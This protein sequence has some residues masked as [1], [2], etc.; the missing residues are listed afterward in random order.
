[1]KKFGKTSLVCGGDE[2]TKFMPLKKIKSLD[3][4]SVSFE[5]G[6]LKK[7]KK[8]FVKEMWDLY[9]NLNKQ[10][11]TVKEIDEYLVRESKKV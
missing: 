7:D 6:I 2:S 4:Y 3:W 11:P 1:M 8:K 5:I 10:V 9:Y